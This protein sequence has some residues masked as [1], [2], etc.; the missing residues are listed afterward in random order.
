MMGWLEM[1]VEMK[2][3]LMAVVDRAQQLH[4]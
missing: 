2:M 1:A 4:D 3:V